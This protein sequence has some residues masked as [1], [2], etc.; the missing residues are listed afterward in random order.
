MAI[1]DSQMWELSVDKKMSHVGLRK[2]EDIAL[3]TT[4]KLRRDKAANLALRKDM[5]CSQ[6]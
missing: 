3:N 6:L 4:T 1:S 5:C 2:V